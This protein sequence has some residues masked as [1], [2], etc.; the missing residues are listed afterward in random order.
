M[1]VVEVA[2]CKDTYLS[3]MPSKQLDINP[4]GTVL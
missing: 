2:E 4:K 3:C 1:I